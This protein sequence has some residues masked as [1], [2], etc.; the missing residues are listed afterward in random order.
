MNYQVPYFIG[1]AAYWLLQQ[2]GRETYR[3]V[4]DAGCGTGLAGRFLKPLVDGSLIGVDLS[5]KM[6]DVARECTLLKGCGLKEVPEEDEE[7]KVDESPEEDIRSS[8]RLYNHL[9]SLDLETATLDEI[10]SGYNDAPAD[11][12]DGFELIVAA[13][14]LVYIGELQ[15]LL[16]NFA[17]LSAESNADRDAFLI[18][19]CERIEEEDAPSSGWKLQNSGRYAHSKSYVVNTAKEAGYRLIGYEEIV[20]RME[21]G[22][23]VQGHLFQFAL[24]L[25]EDWDENE[26]ETGDMVF[27]DIINEDGEIVLS[28]EL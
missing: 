11:A 24:G 18:F 6:L 12:K 15:K 19:S 25:D 8:I 21:K 4:L 7:T 2:G 16:F 28:D 23:D 26:M 13:D 17:K 10:Y 9:T 5:T 20:P 27:M 3:S 14:V 22:K 1:E